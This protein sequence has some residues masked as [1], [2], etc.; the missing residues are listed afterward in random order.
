MTITVTF[1][2]SY[3]E[4][5]MIAGAKTQGYKVE[6]LGNGAYTIYDLEYD[7]YREMCKVARKIFVH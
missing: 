3:D 6:A 7:D 4:V 1:R 2:R 5:V